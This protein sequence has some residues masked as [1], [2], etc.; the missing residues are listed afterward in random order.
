[1]KVGATEGEIPLLDAAKKE[2]SHL[3]RGIG[4]TYACM[5]VC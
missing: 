2:I 5:S 3:G 4:C 1:M